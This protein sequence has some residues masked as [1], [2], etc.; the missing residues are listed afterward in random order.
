MSGELQW[1]ALMD[2]DTLALP[3]CWCRGPEVKVLFRA[4]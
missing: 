4:S 1:L 3:K 2:G